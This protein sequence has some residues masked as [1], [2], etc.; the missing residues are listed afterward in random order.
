MPKYYSQ[1]IDP[2]NY[3]H[4]Y[5][6]YLRKSYSIRHVNISK[7]KNYFTMHR[8]E[9][10]SEY[11]A[12]ELTDRVITEMDNDKIPFSIFLDHS[13]AFDTLDHTIL[14]DKLKYYGMDETAHRLFGSYLKDR[15]QYVDIDGTSSKIKSIITGFPQASILG[16]LLFIIY[17]NDISFASNLFKF[18]I[19]ADDTTLETTI[20]IAINKSQNA[21][22]EN[23]INIE[24]D[25]INDW[26]KCNKLSLN[27]GKSK[28]MIFHN[29]QKK[30]DH[31]NIKIENT[32]IERVQ[33]FD[34]LGLIINENLNWKAHINKI[35]N[36][37]SKCRGILNRLKH[38][39]PISAK[40]HIYI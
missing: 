17:I 15:K 4:Q 5:Q 22:A 33:E 38:F 7:T 14:L 2:F 36:K 6:R 9:H 40:L 13:K 25:L 29:Q 3:C 23:K 31:L 12:L 11:A 27:I 10:S 16:P 34:F 24:L 35:A 39:L 1:T 32:Y 30:V 18:I 28:Y 8:T 20:E 37:I 19:Y 21:S 26:L